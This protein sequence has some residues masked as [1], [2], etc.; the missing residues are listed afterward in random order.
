[1][2]KI[3]DLGQALDTYKG[4]ENNGF[5]Q[6]KD[7]KDTAVVRFLHGDELLPEQ[8][9]FVVHKVQIGGKDRWVQC[10]EESDCPL[11]GSHGKPKLKLF[12]QLMDK[13]DGKRKTWERGER[14]IPTILGFINKY[15]ALANRPYEIERHGKK[16]DNNTTYQLYPLD[17]DEKTLSDLPERQELLGATGFILK[18]STSDMRKVSDGSFVLKTTDGGSESKSSPEPQRRERRAPSDESDI[19]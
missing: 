14:F 1:M 7:D 8:D 4:G 10:T 2:A 6:L 17:K 19:F 12:L 3:R 9:W 11:C 5:F 18:L 16:G 15:G 13:R